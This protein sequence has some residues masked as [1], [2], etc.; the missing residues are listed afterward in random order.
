[1]FIQRS[2]ETHPTPTGVALKFKVI[3]KLISN[4]RLKQ[5]PVK[6]DHD[7]ERTFAGRAEKV[8]PGTNGH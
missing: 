7:A 8:N 2:A 4:L 5:E 3:D 1:M 6:E